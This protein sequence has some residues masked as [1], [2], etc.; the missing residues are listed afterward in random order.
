[1]V[2]KDDV[3]NLKTLKWFFCAFLFIPIIEIMGCWFWHKKSQRYC[4]QFAKILTRNPQIHLW[5]K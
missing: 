4:A 3:W 2:D 5:G 1:M